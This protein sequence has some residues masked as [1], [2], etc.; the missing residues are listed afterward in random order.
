MDRK[1]VVAFLCVHN[2]CRSQMAEALGRLL[3][4]DVFESCSAGTAPKAR[5]DPDAVRIM[6]KLYGIELEREQYPKPLTSLP[7]VD[8]VVTMGCGVVCPRFHT[9]V[10][11][12]GDSPIRQGWT[13]QRLCIRHARSKRK[14]AA[15]AHGSPKQ[16]HKS[17]DCLSRQSRFFPFPA[18]PQIPS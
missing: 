6:R 15:S 9:S 18:P 11:K 8:I 10:K 4:G 3:A 7:D 13:M 14:S 1:P 12:T 5:L 16:L 2:A 17:R